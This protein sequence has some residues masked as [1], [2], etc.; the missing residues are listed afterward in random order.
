MLFTT[1]ATLGLA[2]LA[3]AEPVEVRRGAAQEPFM[4]IIFNQPNWAGAART[5]LDRQK[6]QCINLGGSL[7]EHVRSILIDRQG[8]DE[9]ILFDRSNCAGRSWSYRN[10]N[11]HI[12]ASKVSSI[13]CFRH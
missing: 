9:C 4:G 12:R 6:G 3:A 11:A 10:N 1:V 5:I 13:V 2:T 8:R 7:H